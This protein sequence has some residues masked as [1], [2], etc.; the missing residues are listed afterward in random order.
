MHQ[1][2]HLTVSTPLGLL[3][4]SDDNL[5]HCPQGLMGFPTF[6][7]V[8]LLA[9]PT[10]DSPF[11]LLQ[12]IDHPGMVMVVLPHQGRD[13]LKQEDLDKAYKA[14]GLQANTQAYLT[15][16]IHVDGGAQAIIKANLKCPILLNPDN[17][18]G[19]QVMLDGPYP[20]ALELIPT[21]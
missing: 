18:L 14:Y 6:K 16:S 11:K 9:F 3:T 7:D 8:V 15:L 1:S 4:G 12:N 20:L 5:F 10:A 2:T 21:H 13:L 17:N 19:F